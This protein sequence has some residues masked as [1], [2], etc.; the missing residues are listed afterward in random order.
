MKHIKALLDREAAKRNHPLELNL[1][2]PDPL[3]VARKQDDDRA[4][5]L[6]ALFS[7]GSA[8]QIVK[9]L[10]SID[11]EILNEN[12][13]EIEHYMQKRYYRF[14]NAQ[15]VAEIFKTFSRLDKDELHDIALQGYKEHN[16]I[17]DA[18]RYILKKL[19]ILNPYT[20]LGYDFLL[21][22]TPTDKTK[23]V[24][25]HKRWQLFFRWMVRKDVLDL[26]R[27]EEIDKADLIIPLDTHTF[28]VSQKLGLLNRKTYDLEAALLLTRKL[29]E[30]DTNDPLKYDFALYRIGQERLV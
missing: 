8:A 4:I 6:C 17:L 23:G 9:F 22:Q 10:E 25:P 16:K 29:K 5:L 2:R 15:D 21:G 20:S 1:E 12:E 18:S 27:W 19:H 3:F 26:G 30:F 28:K 11:F 13:K 24:S 7:Y 14:Q